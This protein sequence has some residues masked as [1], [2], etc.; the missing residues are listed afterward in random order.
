MVVAVS[1]FY[2]HSGVVV[3]AIKLM[4]QPIAG[5]VTVLGLKSLLFIVSFCGIVGCIFLPLAHT[6]V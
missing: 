4:L 3:A 6:A 1:E 5:R 2:S